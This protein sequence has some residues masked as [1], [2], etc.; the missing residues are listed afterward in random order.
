MRMA[1][2]EQPIASELDGF[3]FLF[4]F[5]FPSDREIQDP[6]SQTHPHGEAVLGTDGTE[7]GSEAGAPYQGIITL[8]RKKWT[9]I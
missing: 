1:P 5:F 3:F 9:M 7:A 2:P 8:Y 6:D 4:G